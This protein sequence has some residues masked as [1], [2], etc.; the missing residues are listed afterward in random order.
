MRIVIIPIVLFALALATGCGTEIGD[1]CSD[2]LD[3]SPDGD[4]VCEVVSSPGGYC[5]VRGC[6]AYSC[7]EEAVCVRFF[8]AVFPDALCDPA[9]EDIS[10]DNCLDDELCTLGGTCAPRLSEYRYCMRRCGSGSDCRDDYECRDEA[11]MIAHG[12]EPVLGP[13]QAGGSLPRFC[14][15]AS[16]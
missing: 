12:G 14:A 9:L 5:T 8:S 7:P 16:N 15:A 11:L 10:E 3:C 6:D 4:R 1:G 13:D 2:S